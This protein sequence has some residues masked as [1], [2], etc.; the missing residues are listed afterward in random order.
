M[1][2]S[3]IIVSYDLLPEV[4][5]YVKSSKGQKNISMCTIQKKLVA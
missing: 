4:L 3:I 2:L 5:H 1:W